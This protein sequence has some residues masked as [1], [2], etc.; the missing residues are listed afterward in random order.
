[1][2]YVAIALTLG[3]TLYGQLILKWR[4]QSVPVTPSNLAGF[5]LDPWVVSGF[6]AAFLAS[7]AWMVAI[8]RVDLGHAYP[9]MSLNFVL[10]VF[11]GAWFFSEALTPMKLAGLALIVTGIVIG[12]RG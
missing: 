8:S 6:A 4:L 2:A 5:L 9:F 12:S 7:L 3:F 1:M 10:V 11:A